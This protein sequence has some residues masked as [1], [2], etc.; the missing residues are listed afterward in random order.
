MSLASEAIAEQLEQNMGTVLPRTDLNLPTSNSRFP[1][2]KQQS[3]GLNLALSN[4]PIAAIAGIPGSG[5]TEIALAA[6]AT[7]ITYQRSVLIVA[8]SPS[9]LQRYADANL[10]LPP[11]FLYD[12]QSPEEGVKRWLNEQ[13]KQP[14]LDFLPI[15]QLRDSLLEDERIQ[16][17]RPFWLSLIQSGNQEE[18]R[19]V[20]QQ[21][22]PEQYPPRQT[23]LV[24]KLQTSQRLLQQRNQ[25][26]QAYLTL[27][28]HGL[29]QLAQTT[30]HSAKIPWLCLSEQ[31]SRVA[32]R[33]FD[34]VIVADSHELEM[35]PLQAVATSAKKLLLLGELADSQSAFVKLFESLFPAYRLEL[36]ENH[37]LHPDLAERIFPV[38]YDRHPYTPPIHTYSSRSAERL[39]WY[40]TV[41]FDQLIEEVERQLDALSPRENPPGLL[42]F[43]IS[44]RDRLRE[45]F[46]QRKLDIHTVDNWRGKA[47]QQLWIIYEGDELLPREQALRSSLTRARDALVVFGDPS[48]LNNS[49]LA[50]LW[51]QKAFHEIRELKLEED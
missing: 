48:A 41:N 7:A 34:I 43:S 3:Q 46:S 17:Q 25:L 16:S 45:R 6:I 5:K 28:D 42:T 22:F 51:R 37:R 24:Q 47:C 18:L 4:S 39:V 8:P 49:L 23:L 33:Q 14:K 21:T 32:R 9:R 40:H 36:S 1:F 12:E 20:V 26:H 2:R 50:S 27:S 11:L 13:F 38:A 44:W 10:P 29:T 35:K 15:H 19:T 31:I 30:L